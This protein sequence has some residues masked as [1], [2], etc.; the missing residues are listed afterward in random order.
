MKIALLGT[1]R[2]G[3]IRRHFECTDFDED[4]SFVHSTKEIIQIIKYITR[5]IEIP[6]ELNQFCFRR[7]ILNKRPVAYS[8]RF[9]SQFN[10]ADMFV[11][12]VCAMRKYLY[13]GCYLHHLAVDSR[14]HY[15][16]ETP[17]RILEG[18]V[19]LHQDRQEIENDISEIMELVYPRKIMLVSHI[20]ATIDTAG[21]RSRLQRVYDATVSVVHGALTLVLNSMPNNEASRFIPIARRAELISLLGE[22]SRGKGIDFFDPTVA[23]SRY[24]QK[25]ILQ[26]E[27]PGLPPGHYTDFGNKVM[28]RLFAAEIKRMAG[29]R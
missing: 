3:C 20:N 14:L 13:R 11:I 24:S 21:P 1:C 15:Y 9:L 12:E 5:Q 22:I 19:V 18:T 27:E 26:S 23:F 29:C 16:K 6:D 28:G 10:D 2:I 8:D 7:G 25:R 4:I 17:R